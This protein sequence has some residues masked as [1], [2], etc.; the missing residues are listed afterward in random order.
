MLFGD[1]QTAHLP[2]EVVEIL[3]DS[4]VARSQWDALTKQI[5]VRGQ[6]GQRHSAANKFK[7]LAK[8][9]G[10]TGSA[11]AT[12]WHTW[13]SLENKKATDKEIQGNRGRLRQR[14]EEGDANPG[15]RKFHRG[16]WKGTLIS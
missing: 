16:N 15:W 6:F 7:Q 13:Y 4:G 1:E 12:L 11:I 3:I 14:D 2:E 9:A 5:Q 8:A 10:L